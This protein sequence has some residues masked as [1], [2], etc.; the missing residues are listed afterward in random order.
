MTRHDG[1]ANRGRI[2]EA[3]R[4]SP[5]IHVAE[6]AKRLGLSWHTTAYHL[7]VLR[8]AGELALDK[9]GRDHHA[10]PNG[11][12]AKDRHRMALLWPDQA[13]DLL[14]SLLACRWLTIQGLA[15]RLGWS[16]R[17]VQRQVG[18]LVEGGLV[19]RIGDWRPLFCVRAAEARPLAR[20]LDGAKWPPPA[21][22][23]WTEV[24]M[25][26][27]DWR[28]F[29]TW[30]WLPTVD[31]LAMS[32]AAWSI[33]G[34]PPQPRATSDLLLHSVHP[35]DRDGLERLLAD[36][37]EEGRPYDHVLR[38]VTREGERL[39]RQRG[40][41]TARDAGGRPLRLAGTLEDV[42]A[43]G[44]AARMHREWKAQHRRSGRSGRSGELERARARLAK[45]HAGPASGSS[46]EATPLPRQ[47]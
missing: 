18:R 47:P 11:L 41:I 27:P 7:Q 35:G 14:A 46:L 19:E 45:A 26:G 28:R 9:H 42:T 37:L 2:L 8:A 3:V 12:S 32:D 24:Q 16:E 13:K 22:S 33:C 31:R 21:A 30:E 6:L 39:V 43:S 38:V 36:A 4:T 10:F 17:R 40:R 1:P 20:L 15:E 34:V 25:S 44:T 29:G 5:G 23:P